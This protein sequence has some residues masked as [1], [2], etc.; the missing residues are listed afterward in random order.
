[1]HSL[2]CITR[3]MQFCLIH[4]NNYISSLHHHHRI[5]HTLLSHL[6]VF[7]VMCCFRTEGSDTQRMEKLA[8]EESRRNVARHIRHSVR[9]RTE[10]Q[11]W[12]ALRDTLSR[13]ATPLH[14][15]HQWIIQ[16]VSLNLYISNISNFINNVEK[17][18]EQ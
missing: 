18:L 4:A 15:S 8:S 13:H 17:I 5:M 9:K 10:P 12:P 16:I 3:Y 2:T 6:M 1:M 14:H 7:D 11:P